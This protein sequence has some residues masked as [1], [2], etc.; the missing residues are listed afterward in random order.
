MTLFNINFSTDWTVFKKIFIPGVVAYGLIE[1]VV[2]RTNTNCTLNTVGEI[3]IGVK[4]EDQ[5]KNF[6]A[7]WKTTLFLPV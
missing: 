2:Y 1:T 7:T 6:I 5:N 3:P 4:C